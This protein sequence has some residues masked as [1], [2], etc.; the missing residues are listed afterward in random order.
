MKSARS[1]PLCNGSAPD[2]QA[3]LVRQ[4]QPPSLESDLE[5]SSERDRAVFF[6][7]P[8]AREPE[9]PAKIN[10]SA[11]ESARQG[12]TQAEDLV[13]LMTSFAGREK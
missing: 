2:G 8:F 3:Q 11:S 4:R 12:H 6:E 1:A 9:M 13:L 5:R 7:S 10:A